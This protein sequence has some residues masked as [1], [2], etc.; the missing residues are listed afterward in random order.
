LDN[1]YECVRPPD[2]VFHPPLY[3]PVLVNTF[4]LIVYSSI[5]CGLGRAVVRRVRRQSPKQPKDRA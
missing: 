4:L 2:S 5:V 3:Q 1:F